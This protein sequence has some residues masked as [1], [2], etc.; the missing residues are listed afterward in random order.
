MGLDAS[1]QLASMSRSSLLEASVLHT[2][3]CSLQSPGE[4]IKQS[5]EASS[6]CEASTQQ[7]FSEQELEARYDEWVL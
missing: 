1:V 4:H 5:P 2:T 7:A 3:K 6:L